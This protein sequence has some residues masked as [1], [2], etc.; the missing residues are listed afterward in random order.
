MHEHRCLENITRLYK[1]SGKCDDQKQ[2]KAIL[3][4]AMVSTT[5]LFTGNSPMLPNK[6]VT[7]NNPSARKS[8]HQ[9]L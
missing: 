1:A 9:F 6:F 2:Y 8:P 5:E 7:V 4:A 3:G